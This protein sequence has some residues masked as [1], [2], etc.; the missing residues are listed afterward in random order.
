MKKA[1]L[2]LTIIALL[3]S[4]VLEVHASEAIPKPSVPQFTVEFV[5]KS[6]D[7]PPT[8]EST[9]DPYTNK[10]TTTTIPG[11]HTDNPTIKVTIK[12]QPF[13]S[14]LNGNATNLYYNV[15][16]KGH[17]GEDWNEQYSYTEYS[18]G[19]LPTQS[20]SEYTI[21]SFPSRY[22]AGDEVDFQA[23]ATWAM[24]THII[25]LSTHHILSH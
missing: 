12:N 8:T 18:S 5:D 7:V 24:Y 3:F 6:Y 4:L 17:F 1:L 10:T 19:S 2:T 16:I 22:R 9:T 15:R 14:T 13:P 23:E 11:Y 25:I 20:S 21:L